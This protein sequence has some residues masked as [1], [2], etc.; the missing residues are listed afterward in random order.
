MPSRWPATARYSRTTGRSGTGA[1]ARSVRRRAVPEGW[2]DVDAQFALAIWDRER[3]RLT[4]ARD[5][6]GVRFLY[7]W[8][9]RRRRDLRLG[10]QGAA[11][12]PRGDPRLRRGRGAPV[13]DLPDRAGAAHAVR[14]HPPRVRP[15][16]TVELAPDGAAVPN[17]ATGTCSTR[18]STS[19]TTRATTSPARASCTTPPCGGVACPDRSVR[20]SPAATTPAPT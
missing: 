15:A 13:P 4:L 10:D 12:A 18:P 16:A 5:P 19:G 9:I 17:A 20:C 8:S 6:L 3:R 2:H 14:W 7:Y 11:A 1:A